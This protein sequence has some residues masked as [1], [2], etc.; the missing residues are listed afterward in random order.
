M[1]KSTQN[2]IILIF[3]VVFG[4]SL[5]LD[6][7]TTV[8]YIVVVLIIIVPIIVIYKMVK[9]SVNTPSHTELF[10]KYRNF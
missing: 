2:A 4:V 6:F 9:P 8:V 7:G 5:F 3:A 10:N 1:N